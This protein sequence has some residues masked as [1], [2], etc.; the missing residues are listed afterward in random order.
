MKT[1]KS[2]VL[3]LALVLGFE[4]QAQTA[5][6]D[7]TEFLAKFKTFEAQ[8][9]PKQEYAM[10]V[11]KPK[12]E[13]SE[14]IPNALKEGQGFAIDPQTRLHYYLQL[15]KVYDPETGY[16][17]SYDPKAEYRVDVN[18]G[19]VFKGEVEVKP[20]RRKPVSGKDS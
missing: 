4:V 9:Y 19:K 15:G 2:L 8:H 13:K 1:I 5:G 18:A 11:Y 10:P 20:E 17:I 3:L 7:L 6:A 16:S 14:G 12:S